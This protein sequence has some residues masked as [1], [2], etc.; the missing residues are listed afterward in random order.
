MLEHAIGQPDADYMMA[1]SHVAPLQTPNRRLQPDLL[2]GYA[3]RQL[4]R[5]KMKN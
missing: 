3:H 1:R 5:I 2:T 4:R